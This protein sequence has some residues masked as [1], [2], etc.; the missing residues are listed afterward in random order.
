MNLPMNR[1]LRKNLLLARVAC[2]A[3]VASLTLLSAPGFLRAEQGVEP[4]A[5]FGH[6][7][8]NTMRVVAVGF[9]A[10]PEDAT[11]PGQ[12][13][14][15]GKRASVMDARRNL[16]E[17][18]K[19][20]RI[21]SQTTV[22]NFITQDDTVLTRIQGMLQFCEVEYTKR[23]G[24]GGYESRVSM[25]LTGQLSQELMRY[26]PAAYAPPTSL[27]PPP[28]ATA[29]PAPTLAPTSIPTAAPTPGPA[30][31]AAPT[32]GPDIS[33]ATPYTGLVV[34]ARNLGFKPSLKPVLQGPGGQVYPGPNLNQI[35]AVQRGL[36][37]YYQD[38]EL[39]GQSDQAGSNPLFITAQSLL[40]DQASS[41]LV[42]ADDAET[43]QGIL[44]QPDNFLDKGNVVIV[45]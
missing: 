37:R 22:V 45:F 13:M 7:D 11:G 33:G 4:V 3:C 40:G 36:V 34:D 24:D 2:L 26:A 32:A 19:G 29:Q 8:W 27:G 35:I 31:T 9:G 5:Q 21:D 38:L 18:I 6:V 1:I 15:M 43:L 12:A 41:L 42:K 39:A 25:P 30:P 17:V 20:V 14:A 23:L 16:L 44:A 28:T 10:A